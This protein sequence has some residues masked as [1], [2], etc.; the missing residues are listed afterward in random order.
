MARRVI[1]PTG[2]RRRRWLF[3]LCLVVTV[4]AG[5]LFIP[6]ALAV[7]D[8]GAFELDGNATN[9]PAVVGDDWDNVCHEVTITNDTTN[10]ITDEC[11]SAT[12]T[13]GALAVSWAAEASLNA[14]IFTGG[15]SK[16]PQDVSNWAWKDGAGGLPDKDNLLHSFAA[17]YTLPADTDGTDGTL[18]PTGTATTCD[19]L[20]FGSD[21]YDNSGD[22]QQ[23]FWFF[24]NKITLGNVSS[25][26]GFNFN[27]LHKDGDVLVISDFSNGGT[28]STITVFKWDHLC[29]ATNKP[30][31]DCADANLRTLASSTAAN[32]NTVAD[33]DQFCGIVNPGPGLT[34]SPWSFT[35]KS[36]NHA[37]LNGEFYEGGINLSTLGLAGECFSSVASETRSSTSTTATLKDFVLG[38][39]ATCVPGMATQASATVANPVIPGSPVHD[40]ATITVTGGTNPDDP[41]GTVTFFLCGPIASGD[42]STG[43]TNIG[44]GTLNGGVNTTDG[45]ATA[46]SPDVNTSTSPLAAG[47]YCFRAEW[48][49][50]SNYGPASHTDAT[51]ECFAVKD[52]SAISTTQNWLPNDSAHVTTGSGAGAS[53]TVT[54][55]LYGTANCTG[56]AITTFA[57]RPVDGSGNA[58]TNNTTF[59]IAVSPGETISW[60]ATFTPT[61]ANA[62]NGSTSHCETSTVTIN[63]DIGS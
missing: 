7:H 12:D 30:D 45:I 32:C 27:G 41:T 10:A 38:Q 61:D 17:R 49:G 29:T 63:N 44:T 39:F 62:V 22:A 46:T 58:S 26:G 53:G 16:D 1:G 34:P 23:G 9:D 21:R 2:S 11:A 48:P 51:V 6:G 31:S 52:T 47:R 15:G 24:Q 20:Y 3:L 55:T 35:D 43:G 25:G 28:T 8:T 54:F 14:T 13:S 60:R 50:D 59:A 5:I 56:T 42:C 57:N 18:C 33:G 36:G 37:F 4:G 19:I 40:T